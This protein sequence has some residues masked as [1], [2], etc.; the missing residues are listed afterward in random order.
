MYFWFSV[1]QNNIFWLHSFSTPEV[2]IFHPKRCNCWMHL[3]LKKNASAVVQIII[4]TTFFLHLRL[5]EYKVHYHYIQKYWLTRIKIQKLLRDLCV[6]RLHLTVTLLFNYYNYY[7]YRYWQF[8]FDII[9][10]W[11]TC[12]SNLLSF[13]QVWL[14]FFRKL[15]WSSPYVDRITRVEVEDCDARWWDNGYNLNPKQD[16]L[17]QYIYI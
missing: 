12:L 6:S 1:L 16:G 17:G 7:Y 11:G 9:I 14:P 3:M 10:C 2:K 4:E 15:F 5:I 13:F 8:D